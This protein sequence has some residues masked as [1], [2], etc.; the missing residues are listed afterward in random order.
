VVDIIGTCPRLKVAELAIFRD[1]HGDLA[2]P[3]VGVSVRAYE[4][5]LSEV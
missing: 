3:L 1:Y 2:A 5:G 4:D